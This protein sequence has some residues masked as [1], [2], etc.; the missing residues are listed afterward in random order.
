MEVAIALS[1]VLVSI[2]GGGCGGIA[3]IFKLSR[4]LDRRFDAT[5]EK[6][7]QLTHRYDVQRERDLANIQM[8]EYRLI[9]SEKSAEHK[10]NRFENAI[11]QL[12]KYL[13]KNHDYRPRFM[14]PT[15]RPDND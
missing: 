1:S 9:Q 11:L 3:A 2:I 7:S 12:S 15:S 14:F 4:Q 5:D 8:L 6:I 10:F 13:E